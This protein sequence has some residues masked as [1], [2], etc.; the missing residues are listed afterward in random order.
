MYNF[1]KNSSYE[2]EVNAMKEKYTAAE[3]EIVEFEA[4]DIITGSDELSD[5]LPDDDLEG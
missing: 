3:M 4:K 2:K 5:E 1:E